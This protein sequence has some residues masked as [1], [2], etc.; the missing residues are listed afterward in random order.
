VDLHV[1]VLEHLDHAAVAGG[2]VIDP[3]QRPLLLGLGEGFLAETADREQP[4]GVFL[5]GR[6]NHLPRAALL[7]QIT[8]LQHH[9][10]VG[11]LGDH[12][13]VVGDVDGGG[14]ELAHHVLDRRQDLDLGRDVERGGRLVEDDEVRAAR[15]RHGGHGPLQLAAG[16]LV[17]VAETDGLGL[18]QLQAPIQILGVGLGLGARLD[19]VL[20]RHLGVLVDQLVRRVE[21][22]GRALR[23]IGDARAAQLAFL[24]L[25]G[26][27]QIDAVE[28]DRAA[29]DPAAGPGEAHGGDADGRLAG[30]GLADKAQHLAAPQVEVDAVY[31]L[32]PLV[33]GLALDLEAAHLEQD[34]AVPTVACASG[35]RAAH[36]SDAGTSR[37]RS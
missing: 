1:D 9:D 25:A 13:E 11:H 16:N 19:P 8:V 35:H 28:Q 12:R 34:F 14:V 2:H 3:E 32:V 23:H 5:L 36:S 15:H 31:D 30:A 29:D 6:G 27:P 10:A 26:G 22:G 21:R 37:P 18:R 4:A 7:D 33:V 17:R 24:L 20:D